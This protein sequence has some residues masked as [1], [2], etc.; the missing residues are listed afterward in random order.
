MAEILQHCGKTPL[1][2]K[3]YKSTQSHYLWQSPAHCLLT[4]MSLTVWSWAEEVFPQQVY[5]HS[6]TWSRNLS[7]SLNDGTSPSSLWLVCRL[8]FPILWPLEAGSQL[9]AHCNCYGTTCQCG[10]CSHPISTIEAGCEQTKL[11]CRVTEQKNSV[12]WER[13]FSHGNP[14]LSCSF[15][16]FWSAMRR[17]LE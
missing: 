15:Q 5:L 2:N 1:M 4:A 16:P 9:T 12:L 10:F 17:G 8:T 14:S 11:N 6:E 7:S 3:M 13:C